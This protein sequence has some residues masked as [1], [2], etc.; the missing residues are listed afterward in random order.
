MVSVSISDFFHDM[1]LL[2]ALGLVCGYDSDSINA[3]F[4]KRRR[5]APLTISFDLILWMRLVY[6]HKTGTR[7]QRDGRSI[8][9]TP[10]SFGP[11][12]ANWALCPELQRDSRLRLEC[13]QRFKWL[14]HK[15][16]LNGWPPRLDGLDGAP[17]VPRPPHVRVQI[18]SSQLPSQPSSLRCSCRRSPADAE[19]QVK[20]TQSSSDVVD[21]RQQEDEETQGLEM[22]I[23]LWK[24]RKLRWPVA[25]RLCVCEGIR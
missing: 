18:R 21:H 15:R 19:S 12:Q 20:A 14:S 3:I 9:G 25:P 5:Q 23:E 13:Q 10:V 8:R 2:Q 17:M 1:L 16:L 4:W 6:G 22:W 24:L 11:F 7:F